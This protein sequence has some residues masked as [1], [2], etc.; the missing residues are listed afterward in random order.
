MAL[1][2]IEFEAAVSGTSTDLF[3]GSTAISTDN[4]AHVGET[5]T[6]EPSPNGDVENAS[7]YA[8]NV[9]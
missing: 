7:N 1:S 5:L 8:Q 4:Q 3:L 2:N 9:R 6:N